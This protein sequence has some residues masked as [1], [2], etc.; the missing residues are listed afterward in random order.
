MDSQ[1][2]CVAKGK[3]KRMETIKVKYSDV[4]VVT[5]SPINELTSQ[6][7]SNKRELKT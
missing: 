7:C 2:E 1:F 6:N 4:V 5:L 3:L